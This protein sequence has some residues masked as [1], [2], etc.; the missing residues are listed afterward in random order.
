MANPI[1]LALI[2]AESEI[3]R[4]KQRLLRSCRASNPLLRQYAADFRPWLAFG[5][6]VNA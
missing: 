1:A 3:R 5:C 6:N 2:P 4:T